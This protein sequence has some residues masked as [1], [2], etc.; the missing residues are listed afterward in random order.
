MKIVKTIKD[1]GIKNLVII[2]IAGVVLA[3]LS[4]PSFSSSEKIAETE[5]DDEETYT[6]E[7]YII[8]Q[9]ERLKNILTKVKGAGEIEVMITLKQHDQSDTN[10]IENYSSTNEIEG[11][12]I[13]ASGA[14]NANTVNDIVDAV[15]I[16]FG[17]GCHKVKVMQMK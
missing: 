6:E 10:Y 9:E 15:T 7:S 11:I 1:I 16:L 13:I 17:I 2:L 3:A 14:D 4:L 5:T 12:L 8:Y